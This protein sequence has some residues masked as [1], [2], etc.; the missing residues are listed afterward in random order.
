MEPIDNVDKKNMDDLEM[1][2]N[3]LLQQHVKRINVT[4][5]QPFELH[6]TNAEAL[7]RYF[8]T[9]EFFTMYV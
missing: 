9:Q 2:G 4:T 7:D 1:V 3:K 5:F 8:L 6:H